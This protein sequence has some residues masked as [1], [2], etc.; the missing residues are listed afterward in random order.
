MSDPKFTPG[1][2]SSPVDYDFADDPLCSV[3][4]VAKSANAGKRLANFYGPDRVANA[5]L[6]AA[7]PNLYAALSAL[8]DFEASPGMTFTERMH[9]ARAALAKARGEA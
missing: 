6:F 5:A 8:L 2:W 9:L 7:S 3:Q 4:P 1:P